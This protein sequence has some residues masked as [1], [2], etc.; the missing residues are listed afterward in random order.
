MALRDTNKTSK[1]N[2][3]EESALFDPLLVDSDESIKYATSKS[4]RTQNVDIFSLGCVF[5]YVLVPGVHPFGRWYE[6]EPNIMN[7]KLDL[8]HLEHFDDAHDLI[9]RMLRRC[10]FLNSNYCTCCLYH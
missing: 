10:D 4:R 9:G 8:S 7:G 6:R 1:T 5:H 3:G 2:L